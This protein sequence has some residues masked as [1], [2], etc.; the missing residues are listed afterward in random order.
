[1]KGNTCERVAF[2]MIAITVTVN[3]WVVA[4]IVQCYTF[5]IRA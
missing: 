1:M 2:P 3:S 5:S 4:F